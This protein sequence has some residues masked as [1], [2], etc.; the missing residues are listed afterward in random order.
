VFI[1]ELAVV[2]LVGGRVFGGEDGGAGR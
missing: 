2:L 1:E